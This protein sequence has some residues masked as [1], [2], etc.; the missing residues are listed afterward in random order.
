MRVYQVLVLLAATAV[1]SAFAVDSSAEVARSISKLHLDPSECYKLSN[2]DLNK[3][4]VSLHFSNG[5]IIFAEPVRGIRPGAVYISSSGENRLAF[6]PTAAS[7]RLA[8]ER[9]VH[10][11]S[12]NEPFGRSLMLFTDGTDASL[13]AA[14]SSQH[15]SKDPAKGAE[16]AQ[17]WASIFAHIA[18]SFHT[19]I[20]RDLIDGD[21]SRGVFYIGVAAPTIGDFDIFYDP[22]A[23]D[24]AVLG[25]L[26]EGV[27]DTIATC[28]EPKTPAARSTVI[29]YSLDVTLHDDQRVSVITKANVQ[30]TGKATRVLVFSISR[31]MNVV[32]AEVDG[33]PAE[34]FQSQSLRSNLIRDQGNDE[35][36]V[37]APDELKAGSVHELRIEH[38]GETIKRFQNGE[39][40][41]GAREN[42]YPRSGNAPAQYDLKFHSSPELTLVASG[43]IVADYLE[44]NSRLT[45]WRT[46]SP[47]THATFNAGHF[48][49]VP[50]KL[51]DLSAEV[52]FPDKRP[53]DPVNL[54]ILP[55]A[56]PNYY[57]G[58]QNIGRQ[59]LS[60]MSFMNAYLGT[61]LTSTLLVSPSPGP[62]GQ[63]LSG[64]VFLPSSLYKDLGDDSKDANSQSFEERLRDRTSVPHEV[65][66][67]WWGV[68]VRFATYHDEWITEALANYSALLHTEQ[69]GGA[70][71][72]E[73][74]VE[75]YKSALQR[76]TGEGKTVLDIGPVTWG[77]YRLQQLQPG[78]TWRTLTY[79][80]GTLII[81]GLRT[82]M[83]DTAFQ[84]FLRAL[85]KDFQTRPLSTRDLERM[86][87]RYVAADKAQAFF[88]SAVYGTAMP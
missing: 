53:P 36:F 70:A 39:L 20:V 61:A 83:G 28:C 50:V 55:P 75:H 84:Q 29:S 4:P 57:S 18:D 30:V 35:F 66:H 79:G 85:F 7:E 69:T 49:H 56:G 10:K 87:A 9:A 41:I 62:L 88:E 31:L 6:A 67:Q 72:T 52:Y 65:A 3:G 45:Q 51:N 74:V 48:D 60:T 54:D 19:R 25:K 73:E 86:A 78:P 11:R 44:G 5:W 82:M 33:V 8:L 2:V 59:T 76:K 24:E 12:L 43:K 80:K 15:A 68:S 38:A 40:L 16:V 22:T 64:H 27:F 14:L 21:R 34:V 77:S 17:E 23:T 42:W 63:D 58:A 46:A 26:H 13:D 47:I 71:I 37:I 81:H 1:P 32:R